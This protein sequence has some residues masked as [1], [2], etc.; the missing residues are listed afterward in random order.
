[1]RIRSQILLIASMLMLAI[2]NSRLLFAQTQNA[3]AASAPRKLPEIRCDERADGFCDVA[4]GIERT[5]TSEDGTLLI[6][7]AGTHDGSVLALR[8]AVAPGMKPG[9]MNPATLAPHDYS[10]FRGGVRIERLDASSDRF[11]TLLSA[12]YHTK[13]HPSLMSESV[14]FTAFAFR[15][16]PEK[17][18]TREV[19]FE[20]YHD[21]P[22]N[23]VPQCELLLNVNLPAGEIKIREKNQDFRECTIRILGR[24]N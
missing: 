17:I 22:G 12:F 10:L 2:L 11:A 14:H 21:D 24:G 15:G 16:D 6:T 4:M 1:M 20:L 19:L 3:P 7:V 8:I 18:A 13:R 9:D 23:S 5:Q